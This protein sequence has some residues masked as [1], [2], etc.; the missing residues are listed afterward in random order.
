MN[1]LDRYDE[2]IAELSDQKGFEKIV[3]Q[4]MD[5]DLKDLIELFYRLR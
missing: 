1:A 5:Y 2:N 3:I 4:N